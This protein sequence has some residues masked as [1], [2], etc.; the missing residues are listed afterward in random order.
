MKA[1]LEH[2]HESEG[3]LIAHI[4]NDKLILEVDRLFLYRSIDSIQS[5]IKSYLF[6][7]WSYPSP[8]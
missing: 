8:I 5:A 2:V 7:E 1:H 3:L 4:M 6:G